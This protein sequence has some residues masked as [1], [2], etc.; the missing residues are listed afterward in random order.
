[1][2]AAWENAEKTKDGGKMKIHTKN[3]RTRSYVPGGTGG[4]WL[5]AA[6]ESAEKTLDAYK[7]KNKTGSSFFTTKK[8]L[9]KLYQFH[10]KKNHSGSNLTQRKA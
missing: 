10:I 9:K 4:G 5:N 3:F 7:S 2:T 1:L 8:P 6:R